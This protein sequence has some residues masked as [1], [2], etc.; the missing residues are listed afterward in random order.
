MSLTDSRSQTG[1]STN[2][3]F[4]QTRKKREDETSSDEHSEDF[5]CIN[6]VPKKDKELD[7]GDK[8]KDNPGGSNTPSKLVED[9]PDL[10]VTAPK[11]KLKQIK[12][13][14]DKKCN[15]DEMPSNFADGALIGFENVSST[16]SASSRLRTRRRE[17]QGVSSI[18]TSSGKQGKSSA[19]TK[20]QFSV[21]TVKKGKRGRPMKIYYDTDNE[22]DRWLCVVCL[23][24][25]RQ[26]LFL[27]CKH[28]ISCSKCSDR[29]KARGVCPACEQQIEN[30]ETIDPYNLSS[31]L[32]MM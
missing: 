19:M 16:T 8:T 22:D 13:D 23:K 6:D 24:R 5:S 26:I 10:Q 17:C 4:S 25:E 3:D 20:E 12:L 29:V 7:T 32:T 18:K 28:F 11:V 27:P 30:L 21:G 9:I 14:A 1:S 31:R 15:D 2:K